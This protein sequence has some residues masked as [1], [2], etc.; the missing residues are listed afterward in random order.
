[1]SNNGSIVVRILG[2]A[3][4]LSQ[5]LGHAESSLG[6]LGGSVK[7]LA[8]VAA[9]AFAGMQVGAFLKD[10]VGGASDLNE[11]LSKVTAVFGESAGE[12]DKWAKSAAEK[13]GLSRGAALDAAGGF[14]NLFDQLGFTSNQATSMSTGIVNLAADFASFHNADISDVIEAQSAAFRGEYDSLQ[15]FLPLINAAAVEQRALELTHKKTTKELTAQDK[16]LAVQKLMLEG[17]GV[18][19]GDFA[20]TSDGLA[21]KQR[22]LA[23]RFENIKTS[24]GSALLP[25]VLKLTD[26]FANALQPVME[27]AGKIF[28]TIK[29][30]VRAFGEALKYGDVTSDGFVGQMETIGDAIHKLI[31]TFQ[32]IAETGRKAFAWV[33]EFIDSNPT[34]VFAG[35]GAIVLAAVV[36]PFVMWAAAT[37]ATILPV[38]AVTAA[39]G[40][41]VGGIV[42]AYQHFEGFRKAIETIATTLT[43]IAGPAF[44]ALKAVISK[45]VEIV[46]DLWGRFGGQLLGHLETAVNALLQIFE[47]VFEVIKGVFQLFAAVFTGDWKGVWEALKTIF[48]G[49]WDIFVGYF[50]WA[51]NIISTIIG[52]AMAGIS[53]AWSAIWNGLKTVFADIWAGIRTG[54]TSAWDGIVSFFTDTAPGAIADAAKATFDGLKDAAREAVDWVMR[55]LGEIIEKVKEIPGKIVGAIP[56]AGVAKGVFKA[57]TPFADG[58]IVRARSGGTLGL[59]GEAGRDE[60]VIPLPRGSASLTGGGGGTTINVYGALDPAAVARQIQTILLA[61]QRRSGPLGFA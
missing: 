44:E 16:A 42:Y 24:I 34:P 49:I 8:A 9:G 54:I 25:M 4:G 30:G 55:K 52:A 29:L 12:I 21:N 43:G 61:E 11:S 46:L 28:D 20:K 26:V 1:V 35:L 37:L 58:G 2:D 6:S 33:K 40:G 41:L 17:A 23:A 31:P 10:A 57:I 38:I 48:A 27:K 45:F 47:G 18:A 13:L 15:R 56:G 60:A 7:K 36:P 5:S 51:V 50:K 22:I 19:A 14:G 39:I 59:I 3:A 53:A 32:R